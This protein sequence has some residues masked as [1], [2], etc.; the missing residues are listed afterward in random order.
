MNRNYFRRREYLIM[1]ELR[2]NGKL[3]TT[4][5]RTIIKKTCVYLTCVITAALGSPVVPDV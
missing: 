4:F 3:N 1:Y 2:P 5:E